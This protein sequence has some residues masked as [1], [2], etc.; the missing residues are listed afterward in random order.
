MESNLNNSVGFFTSKGLGSRIMLGTDG[1]HSDILRS[2]QSAFFSGHNFDSIDYGETY[3]R[4]RNVHHYLSKNGFSGDSA[5]N[6]VVLSYDTP[7]PLTSSNFLEH[8]LFGFEASD[9]THVISRGKLIVESGN[10]LTVKEQEILAE[11]QLQ[12]V[13]LWKKMK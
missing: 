10:L 9:V 6:L 8:F 1:M 3:R 5:N 4:F 11:A 2:A 13:R 12:A 7:T